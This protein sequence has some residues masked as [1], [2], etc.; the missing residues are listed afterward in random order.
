MYTG[1]QGMFLVPMDID[2]GNTLDVRI[3]ELISE[4][5]VLIFFVYMYMVNMLYR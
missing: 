2:F 5:K 1:E 4:F 3:T